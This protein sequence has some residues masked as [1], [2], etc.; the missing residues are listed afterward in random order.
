MRMCKITHTLKVVSYP[1]FM[2]S[3][4]NVPVANVTCISYQAFL[5]YLLC[6]LASMGIATCQ[7]D[8]HVAVFAGKRT[9]NACQECFALLYTKAQ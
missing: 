5:N 7:Y 4:Y 2:Y 3:I 9:I 6:C 8:L 1:I